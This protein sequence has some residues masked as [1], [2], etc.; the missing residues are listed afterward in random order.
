[1]TSKAVVKSAMRDARHH[2][3]IF[4][5]TQITLM[6]VFLRVSKCAV[7]VRTWHRRVID[8]E[9]LLGRTEKELTEVGMQ[10]VIADLEAAHFLVGEP[11]SPPPPPPS[12][13]HLFPFSPHSSSLLFFLPPSFSFS[14][15]V[16]TTMLG[17]RTHYL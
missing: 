3:P 15:Q 2:P 12:F 13:L 8:L 7:T 10:K 6:A 17:T 4:L 11:R 9:Q 16:L 5:S 1:M 14:I